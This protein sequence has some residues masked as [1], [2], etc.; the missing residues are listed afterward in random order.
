MLYFV[1]TKGRTYNSFARSYDFRHCT[2]WNGEPLSAG[3]EYY[4]KDSAHEVCVLTD[5][6][7]VCHY[8]SAVNHKYERAIALATS[9]CKW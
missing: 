1:F 5:N 6:G 4:D 3:S 2:K 8:Y 7:V 9:E